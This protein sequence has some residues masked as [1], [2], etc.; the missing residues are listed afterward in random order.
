MARPTESCCCQYG[1]GVNPRLYIF[2]HNM[3]CFYEFLTPFVDNLRLYIQ[4]MRDQKWKNP[5]V[6]TLG[7]HFPH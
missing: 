1:P 2:V 4:D 7:F 5:G 3:L 6:A